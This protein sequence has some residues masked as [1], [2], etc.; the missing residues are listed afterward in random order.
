MRDETRVRTL[1]SAFS[2]ALASFDL[3]SFRLGPPGRWVGA[4]PADLAESIWARRPNLVEV[5]KT[6][7]N[8][9]AMFTPAD[10]EFRSPV[11]VAQ[12]AFEA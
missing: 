3:P 8:A 1:D 7:G 11:R 10:I 4:G 6:G 12:S 9:T 2:C 5:D